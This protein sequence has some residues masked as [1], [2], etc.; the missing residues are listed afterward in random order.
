MRT[1]LALPLSEESRE[2]LYFHA[3]NLHGIDKH[4]RIRWTEPENYHLTL[5]FL[6]DVSVEIL[7]DIDE[8]LRNRLVEITPLSL[9]IMEISGF[10]YSRPKVIV[11]QVEKSE[12]LVRLQKKV[13]NALVCAGFTTDR[14]RFSPHITL[15]RIRR[16]TPPSFAPVPLHQEIH[17]GQVTLFKSELYP[18]G[19]RHTELARYSDNL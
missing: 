13:H 7:E 2:Q 17:C 8:E 9:Q 19:A 4:N 5:S 1:F 14:R 12:L 15:A 3:D 6:G 16:G 11:A 10:P 18:D